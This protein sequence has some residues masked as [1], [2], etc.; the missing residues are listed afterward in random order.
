MRRRVPRGLVGDVHSCA[1][2]AHFAKHDRDRAPPT[3]RG[4]GAPSSVV[5]ERA[6]AREDLAVTSPRTEKP[7][8]QPQAN[9]ATMTVAMMWK[10]R[11]LFPSETAAGDVS[12]APLTTRH[13]SMPQARLHMG[14]SL[15]LDPKW[16]NARHVPPPLTM[17]W[18]VMLSP[19]RCALLPTTIISSSVG[20]TGLSRSPFSLSNPVA[21]RVV[22][23]ELWRFL[24]LRVLPGHRRIGQQCCLLRKFAS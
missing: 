18:A 24:T 3:A 15:A 5:L 9:T 10:S 7:A 11:R 8:M 22:L 4:R 20:W 14:A 19:H 6:A 16:P 23:P 2:E 13:C 12:I 17:M 21:H 1:P